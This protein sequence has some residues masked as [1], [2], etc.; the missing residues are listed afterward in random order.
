MSESKAASE[1]NASPKEARDVLAEEYAEE[2]TSFYQSPIEKRLWRD[3]FVMAFKAGYDS[4]DA[5]VSSLRSEVERLNSYT[6][7]G[8]KEGIA[9]LT[10]E[11]DALRD[12][13]SKLRAIIRQVLDC[14]FRQPELSDEWY[15][16]ANELFEGEAEKSAYPGSTGQ[17]VN[18]GDG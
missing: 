1:G 16:A 7:A 2:R 6:I 10:A 9:A 13:E 3:N 14:G 11:R 5:E 17:P 12:A 15:E 4:R 8:Y 18:E